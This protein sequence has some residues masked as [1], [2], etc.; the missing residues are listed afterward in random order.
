MKTFKPGL[1]IGLTAFMILN[2][3]APVFAHNGEVDTN[4]SKPPKVTTN[5]KPEKEAQPE[6]AASK[7]ECEGETRV[8]PLHQL[9]VER[10]LNEQKT[11]MTEQ[12]KPN[13]TQPAKAKVATNAAKGESKSLRDISAEERQQECANAKPVKVMPIGRLPVEN[14]ISKQKKDQKDK[15][16]N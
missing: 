16:N 9:P 11:P 14:A 2:V 5:V 13:Q 4:Q 1:L 7:P 12:Q 10:K 8:I 3:S 15:G 6:Q